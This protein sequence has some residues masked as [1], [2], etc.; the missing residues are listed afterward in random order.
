M[1]SNE[2]L[3]VVVVFAKSKQ[4]PNLLQCFQM[5]QTLGRFQM[6]AT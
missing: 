6:M 2:T 1:L 3:I 5:M 4:T